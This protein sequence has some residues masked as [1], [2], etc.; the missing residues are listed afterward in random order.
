MSHLIMDNPSLASALL[1][2]QI[3]GVLGG[4][5]FDS[6]GLFYELRISD[7]V[8]FIAGGIGDRAH[9]V[10]HPRPACPPKETISC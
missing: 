4:D 10:D 1:P 8:T 5:S 3:V 7:N 6:R 9:A 2:I